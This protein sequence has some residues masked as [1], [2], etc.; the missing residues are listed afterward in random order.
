[1]ARTTRAQFCLTQRPF[2][3]RIEC[4]RSGND[5]SDRL[6]ANLRRSGNRTDRPIADALEWCTGL[7]PTLR[8]LRAGGRPVQ[9]GPLSFSQRARPARAPGRVDALSQ[10]RRLAAEADY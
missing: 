5:R 6:L 7:F 4:R 2:A 9:L 1:M 8:A 3:A 10:N